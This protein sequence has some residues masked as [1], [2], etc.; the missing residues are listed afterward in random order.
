MQVLSCLWTF[1]EDVRVGEKENNKNEVFLSISSLS[2]KKK[3]RITV[4]HMMELTISSKFKR[5]CFHDC[6]SPYWQRKAE[7]G[8]GITRCKVLIPGRG[9]E[10]PK[11]TSFV[12]HSVEQVYLVQREW[13]VSV[14]YFST[15]IQF[16]I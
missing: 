8:K 6:E 1:H 15:S 10:N 4:L 2:K 7:T 11:M 5:K 16:Q 14:I 13:H 3:S 9:T 12:S